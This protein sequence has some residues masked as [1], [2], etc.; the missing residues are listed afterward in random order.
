MTREKINFA[1]PVT[2]ENSVILKQLFSETQRVK[3]ALRGRRIVI[4]G[5]GIR[6]C[7]LLV[8][9]QKQG[10]DDFIFCDNNP[11]KQGNLINSYD[12]VSL[13]TALDYDGGQIFL[14]SPEDS[15]GI[16]GQLEKAGLRENDDWLSF[17]FSAYGNYIAEYLRPVANHVLVLGDCAF[18]H[19]ALA[20]I[21]TDSLGDMIKARLGDNRCKVLAM[22]GIGQQANY[23]IIRSLLENG[24]RPS[25]L[26]LLTV[27]EVLAPKAHLMPRSQH[28]VL[29]NKL[30]NTKK[31]PETEFAEYARL[32]EERFNNFQVE[33]F[34]SFDADRGEASEK[35]YMKMNYLFKIREE[36]EGVIYLKKTIKMLNTEGVPVV[37]YVPPV[38]YFQ[39]E[40]FFGLD[41][42]SK[43]TENFTKLYT[44]LNNE[45]LEYSVADASFLLDIDEFA[46]PNTID[47]TSNFEGRSKL[48]DFL[49]QNAQLRLLFGQERFYA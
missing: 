16:C 35:L 5:S 15:A 31:N 3:E 46:A 8:I 25:S 38:N 49:T 48:I 21:I 39:G 37:L 45:H 6:G 30:V 36:T 32:A 43:Y 22:H 40:K 17:S 23:H 14:V 47:E 10:Y 33:S 20:D 34:A 11:E 28:P 7:C 24:E 4:F 18:T 42:K 27:M 1:W 26:L 19:I 44:F 41:F 12:I 9:L 29:I 13:E 2:S